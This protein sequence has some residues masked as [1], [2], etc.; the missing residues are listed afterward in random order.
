[1]KIDEYLPKFYLIKISF[2]IHFLAYTTYPYLTVPLKLID[3]V[4]DLH[5]NWN[6]LKLF[7]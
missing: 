1:M 6:L 3:Y 5:L 4:I 7:K 2:S